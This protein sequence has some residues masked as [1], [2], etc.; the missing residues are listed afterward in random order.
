[1]LLLELAMANEAIGGGSGE[2]RGGGSGE[3]GGGAGGKTVSASA[4][5]SGTRLAVYGLAALDWQQATYGSLPRKMLAA[6]TYCRPLTHRSSRG[7]CASSTRL[8]GRL[9]WECMLDD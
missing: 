6:V 2:G 3:G 9:H 7:S 4:G 5:A 8:R 1:V